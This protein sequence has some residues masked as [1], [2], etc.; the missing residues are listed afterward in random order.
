M[1]FSLGSYLLGVGTV[2][3]ALALGFGG[4][5]LM[6]KTAVKETAAGPARAERVA[7][8]EQEPARPAQR[9]NA[10]ESSAPPAPAAQRDPPV[11]V[12]AATVQPDTRT[13]AETAK[14]PEPAKPDAAHAVQAAAPQP[15]TRTEAE[16]A[17]AAEGAKQ[18]EAVNQTE[19]KAAVQ[20]R[21]AERKLERH[22]RYAERK[23]RSFAGSGARQRPWEEEAQDEP[24]RRGF[25]FGRRGPRFELYR[26]S[27]PRFDRSYDWGPNDRDDD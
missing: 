16:G 22:K 15:G 25:V 3:G 6:T 27:P 23:D 8:S 1:P 9:E 13:Q 24:E 19:Q 12:Q 21:A 26:L 11:A 10:K 14:P 7:R 17:K 18:G 5:S 2:V 20:K 4:G